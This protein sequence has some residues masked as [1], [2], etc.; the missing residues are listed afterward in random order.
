MTFTA[1]QLRTFSVCGE[2]YRLE[3][4]EGLPVYPT[5]RQIVSRIVR[6]GIQADLAA[7]LAT[8]TLLSSQDAYGAIQAAARAHISSE[9]ALT[10]A[11]VSSGN[12]RVF[13]QVAYQA[14]RLGMMHH[15]VVAPRI[16]P[17]HL[18][19]VVSCELGGH[20][21]TAVVEIQEGSRT[22]RAT[23]VRSRKPEDG[24]SEGDIG[25]LI[26]A[27]GLDRETGHMP[28]SAIVTYLVDGGK[29]VGILKQE[30]EID[31][32]RVA[33]LEHRVRQASAASESR[34]YSPADP[35][36]WQCR[37]CAHRMYCLYV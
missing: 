6:A 10:P 16:E 14:T 34:V 32:N 20:T 36:S 31:P 30:V 35:Q 26:Q 13:Q 3:N 2:R 27:L 19:R 11:Q 4:I 12:S 22:I 7:K 21:L 24:E 18:S 23:K 37:S 5:T 17:T 28:D 8:G 25:L 15:S 29:E 9:V 1:A 33:A